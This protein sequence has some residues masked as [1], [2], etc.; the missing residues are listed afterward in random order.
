MV[1]TTVIGWSW[2]S[3]TIPVVSVVCTKFPGPPGAV[4]RPLTRRGDAAVYELHLDGFNQPL[5]V[6]D[7]PLVLL[8]PETA[9]S[10]V[11]AGRMEF[12]CH[13]VW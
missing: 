7:G 1:N 10:P 8:A 9:G 13:S 4:H 2:V 6:L 5:I 11:A 3:T 12:C